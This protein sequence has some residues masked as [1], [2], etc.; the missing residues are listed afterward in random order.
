MNMEN[1]SISRGNIILSRQQNDGFLKK[2]HVE[3]DSK[4]NPS[5]LSLGGE[6]VEI[7]IQNDKIKIKEGLQVRE[8]LQNIGKDISKNIL[9]ALGE[10]EE[11]NQSINNSEITKQ[12][13][14]DNSET[15]NQNNKLTNEFNIKPEIKINKGVEAGLKTEF[16]GIN[17][18]LSL[19]TNKQI[20]ADVNL[21]TDTNINIKYKNDNV[22]INL[23]QNISS[24]GA[25]VYANYNSQ[26]K[27]L[28]TGVSYVN[29]NT[30]I[31]FGVHNNEKS[32]GINLSYDKKF[33]IKEN[34]ANFYIEANYDTKSKE[35]TGIKAGFTMLF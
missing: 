24:L 23:N 9:K 20:K 4:N 3:I 35:N 15:T 28:S 16:K 21:P 27:N 31:N 8:T 2:N 26:D 7:G 34:P 11:K 17:T 33:K 5:N 1:I 29:K 12:T 19:N 6:L 25:S 22:S 18:K 14:S 32:S 10:D 13:N 30:T